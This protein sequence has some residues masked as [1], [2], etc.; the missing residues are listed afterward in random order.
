MCGCILRTPM[1]LR[2]QG[3]RYAAMS[4]FL[5]LGWSLHILNSK[6]AMLTSLSSLLCMEVIYENFGLV[7]FKNSKQ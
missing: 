1:N 7:Y 4:L 6:I 5:S 3:V 2:W